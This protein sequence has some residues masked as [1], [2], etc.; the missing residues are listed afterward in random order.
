MFVVNEPGIYRFTY[1]V[2]ESTFL[3]YGV[4][5]DSQSR[6]LTA[7]FDNNC[8]HI[9]DKDGQFIPYIDNSQLQRPYSLC[10]DTKDNF[11]ITE[12]DTVK[13][14]KIKNMFAL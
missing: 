6:I 7:D 10:V 11:F 2:I 9:L 13:V 8:I 1:F 3:P 12:P 4:T 5:T 14:R